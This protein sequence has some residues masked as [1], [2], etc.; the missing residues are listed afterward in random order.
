MAEPKPAVIVRNVSKHFAK[1]LALDNVSFEVRRGEFVAI[2]GPDGAGKSTLLRMLAG[3]LKPDS[4]DIEVL[5]EPVPQRLHSIKSRIGYLPQRFSFYL[6]LTVDENIVFFGRAYG[7]KNLVGRREA[8]LSFAGLTPFR[9]RLA[10]QLSGG[11][12]QKLA[13]CCTL[14]HEPEVL[15]LDEPTAGIDPASRREFAEMLGTL[16]HRGITI[17]MATPYLDEAERCH[18]T[19]LL[20]KGK[21]LAAGSA[22]DLKAQI[23]APIYEISCGQPRQVAQALQALSFV[24]NVHSIGENVH[25]S[26]LGQHTV[27]EVEQ[28]LRS[29]GLAFLEVRQ[30]SPTLEDVFISLAQQSHEQ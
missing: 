7:V 29:A 3:L 28:Y 24:T 20:D 17:I 21:V 9:K 26:V 1:T 14:I 4:G 5:G 23:S 13:L 12:K 18:R 6:D 27:A 11:M 16:L 22:P 15:I 10:E 25:F 8:L 2:S 30:T 19:F